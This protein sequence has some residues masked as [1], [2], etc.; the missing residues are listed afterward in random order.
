MSRRTKVVTGIGAVLFVSG[1]GMAIINGTVHES[2]AIRIPAIVFILFGFGCFISIFFEEVDK[3]DKG[4][5]SKGGGS[6]SDFGR[7]MWG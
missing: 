6:P 4:G 3:N 2:L 5:D 1:V 7:G